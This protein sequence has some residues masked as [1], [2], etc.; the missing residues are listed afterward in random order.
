MTVVINAL[1]Q[2]FGLCLDLGICNTTSCRLHLTLNLAQNS[3]NPISI[4]L[5]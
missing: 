2:W 1:S 5:P 4:M 3:A